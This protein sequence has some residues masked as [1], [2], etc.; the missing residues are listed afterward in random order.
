[1]V[2]EITKTNS[3]PGEMLIRIAVNKKADQN[4]ISL[5]NKLPFVTGIVLAE[6]GT[7][8]SS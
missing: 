3:G 8:V 2:L 6:P 5:M 1:M 7:P 4:A